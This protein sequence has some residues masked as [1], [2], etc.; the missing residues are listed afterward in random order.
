M[1]SSDLLTEVWGL[2]KTRLH[3][4]V[5]GGDEQDGLPPD[6]E[7]AELWRRCTDINPDHKIGR[8]SCRERV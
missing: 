1:C 7:A 3:A 2:D 6:E 4:T 5:F 8:A